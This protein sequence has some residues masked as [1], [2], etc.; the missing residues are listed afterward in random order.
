MTNEEVMALAKTDFSIGW[1]L[2][3]LEDKLTYS[4]AI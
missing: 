1:R 3:V 2:K 4:S